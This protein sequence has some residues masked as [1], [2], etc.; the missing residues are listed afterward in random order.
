[1]EGVVVRKKNSFRVV[2]TLD[3][4][5]QSFAVEVDGSELEP[6]DAQGLACA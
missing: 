4:I 1:M 3:A 5:M 2:L 6:L